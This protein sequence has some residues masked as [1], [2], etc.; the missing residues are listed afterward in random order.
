M[1]DD[2]Q[3]SSPK[4]GTFERATR[5]GKYVRT[6]CWLYGPFAIH[7]VEPGEVARCDR[8]TNSFGMF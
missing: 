2:R 4:R 7:K 6:P 5:S 8:P 3:R 1:S